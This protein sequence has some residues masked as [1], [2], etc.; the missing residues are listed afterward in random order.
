MKR[1]YGVSFYF[2]FASVLLLPLRGIA[3]PPFVA[4]PVVRGYGSSLALDSRSDP[5]IAFF[6]GNTLQY[7]TKPDDD[8][9]VQVLAS[10]DYFGGVT[11]ASLALDADDSPHI[12]YYDDLQQDL[13]YARKS[14]GSWIIERVDGAGSDAGLFSAL[15]L[16]PPSSAASVHIAYY[17]ASSQALRYARKSGVGWSLELIDGAGDTGLSPSLQVDA[18]GAPHIAYYDATVNALKYAR[19]A[20]SA[21]ITWQSER[22]DDAAWTPFGQRSALRIDPQGGIHVAYFDGTSGGVKYAVRTRSNWT[23][24]TVDLATAGDGADLALD[25]AED[26]TPHLAYYST[27]GGIR[28]LRYSVRSSGSW[29]VT[30]PFDSPEDGGRYVSLVLDAYANPHMAYLRLPPDVL[31]YASAAV[32]LRALTTQVWPVGSLQPISWSGSGSVDVYLSPDGGASFVQIA[33]GLGGR[34]GILRVPHLPTRFGSIRVVRAAPW[35]VSTTDSFF[36]IDATIALAKFDAT[37]DANGDGTRLTWETRPGPEA[38]IRY[39]VERAGNDAAFISLADGLDRGEF[40]DPSPVASSLYRLIA[41]NGLGEE[42]VLGEASVAAALSADRD[43]IAYPNP[44][45]GPIEILYRVPVEREV[46]LA[47]YDV[48]GRRIRA[49]ASGRVAVGIQTASWD[50]RNDRGESVSAGVY[51]LRLRVGD[52]HE[53]SERVTVVR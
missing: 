17:D 15:A 53:V 43:I 24:E 51:F 41:V 50:R 49:L 21:G 4:E 34:R 39:R 19:R 14:G 7:A 33:A 5:H 3:D 52:G 25:I 42:Y 30:E 26:G 22:V 31:T 16:G 28:V 45:A 38:D 12:S 29:A 8:W 6:E 13:K 18:F 11:V 20:G 2:A 46:D 47:V 35:S 10:I 9:Q 37:R 1:L 36:T 48:S 32:R 40:V 23:I 44:A 27:S